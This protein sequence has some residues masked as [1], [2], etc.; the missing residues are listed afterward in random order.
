MLED[1]IG[2]IKVKDGLFLGDEYAAQVMI[3]N[4]I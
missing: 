4:I 2:G 1:D 3:N